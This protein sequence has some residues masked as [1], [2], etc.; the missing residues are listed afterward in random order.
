MSKSKCI[1]WGSQGPS[2]ILY[3]CL[4]HLGWGSNDIFLKEG[5]VYRRD[6]IS[7][8]LSMKEMGES[9]HLTIL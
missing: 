5:M 9:G 7:W 4:D 2:H 3:T 6:G 8:V 1:L